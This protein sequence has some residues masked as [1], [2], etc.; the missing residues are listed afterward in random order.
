MLVE[1]ALLGCGV[2]VLTALV[3]YNL[4][5][6]AARRITRRQGQAVQGAAV[7]AADAPTLIGAAGRRTGLRSAQAAPLDA[8]VDEALRREL[9]VL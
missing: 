1:I 5:G 6:Y 3:A 8:W 2:A 9:D 7:A 4:M